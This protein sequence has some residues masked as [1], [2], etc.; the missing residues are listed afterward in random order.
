MLT[1]KATTVMA[2]DKKLRRQLWHPVLTSLVIRCGDLIADKNLP[3]QR[4]LYWRGNEYNL[5]GVVQTALHYLARNTSKVNWQDYVDR[6]KKL[7]PFKEV[8]GVSFDED[9]LRDMQVIGGAMEKAAEWKGLF[10][11]RRGNDAHHH[12]YNG[13]LLVT[14]ALYFYIDQHV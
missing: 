11:R 8:K 5:S 4:A 13:S 3:M 2:K 14:I 12:N 1:A 6:Y 10:L 9:S 7:L